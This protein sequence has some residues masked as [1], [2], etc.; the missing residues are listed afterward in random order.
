[1]RDRLGGIIAFAIAA[2]YAYFPMYAQLGLL[3]ADP[4][5]P[6]LPPSVWLVPRAIDWLFVVVAAASFTFILISATRW[7]ELPP[8]FWP[9]C[10][11]TSALLIPALLGFEPLGG[12]TIAFSFFVWMLAANAFLALRREIPWLTTACLVSFLGSGASACAI[13]I[14]AVVTRRPSD[15]YAFEHGRAVGTFLNTNELAGYAVM[16]CTTAVG[17]ALWSRS[18]R[19]RALSLIALGCG[20]IA[21]LLTFSRSG[22]VGAIVAAIVF[23][24]GLRLRWRLVLPG[25]VLVLAVLGGALVFDAH[26]NPAENLSRIAAWKAVGRPYERIDPM[27]GDRSDAGEREELERP[28]TGLPGRDPREVLRRIV[29]SVEHERST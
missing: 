25:T 23:V 16:L 9:G 29:M 19:L 5:D 27:V 10:A 28:P 8:L 26:H 6:A 1:M 18:V 20:L 24:A 11:G 14:A 7:R 21:L 12:L 15:L 22:F 13:A 4:H 3:Y 17:A 2:T